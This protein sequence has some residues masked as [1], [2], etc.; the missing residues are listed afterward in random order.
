MCEIIEPACDLLKYIEQQCLTLVT[1]NIL[2]D[3]FVLF[4]LVFL[5]I[6]PV[7]LPDA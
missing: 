6:L 7:L 2:L 5:I 3:I 1:L 4:S